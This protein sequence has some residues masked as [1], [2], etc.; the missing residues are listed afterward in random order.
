[1]DPIALLIILLHL[2]MLPLVFHML[3]YM[4][5][6]EAF[7]RHTPPQIIAMLYVILSIA[8]TQLVI[9]YF[10]NLFTAIYDLI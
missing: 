8:V 5:L 6:E 3:K 1:M 2:V 4:R 7:K 10:V 9:G